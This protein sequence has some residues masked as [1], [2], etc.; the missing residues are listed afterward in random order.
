MKRALDHPWRA[1]FVCVLLAALT[2]WLIKSQREPNFWRKEWQ[3]H[4]LR[5]LNET[6]TP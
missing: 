3:L 6:R 4:Q 2:W 1:I 5:K